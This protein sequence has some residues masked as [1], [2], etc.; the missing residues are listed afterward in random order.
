MA[1]LAQWL[2]GLPLGIAMRRLPWLFPLLQTL[3]VLAIGMMLSSQI[4]ILL[5]LWRVSKTQGI[6]ARGHRYLPWIWWS[7]VVLVVTGVALVI[8]NPRSSRDPALAAKLLLMVPATLVTLVLA[9]MMRDGD[10][11][12]ER[13]NGRMT[14]SV[15]ATATLVLWLGVTFLGRGRWIF[16]VL[17]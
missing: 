12:D 17:G 8:G 13:A 5:R 4:M 3:H 10:R 6:A 16:N 11:L 7:L 1:A 2:T 9:L 15:A 14:M